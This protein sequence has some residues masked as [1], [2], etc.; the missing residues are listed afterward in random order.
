MTVPSHNH[1]HGLLSGTTVLVVMAALLAVA[2]APA[3]AASTVS[4]EAGVLLVMAAPGE[5]NQVSV[6]ERIPAP[7]QEPSEYEVRDASAGTVAGSGCAPD[8]RSP[9]YVNC[10]MAGV[11]SI[12]IRLG[13]GDD[14]AER[15]TPTGI[16]VSVYGDVGN[17]QITRATL[18]DGGEGNDHLNDGDDLRGGP[19]DDRLEGQRLLDGGDGNDVLQKTGGK[20]GGR[21]AGGSGDDSLQSDDAWADELQC[22]AGRDVIVNADDFDR[23]DGSCESGKGVKPPPK[24]VKA[25]VVVFELPKGVSRPGRDGRLAVWMRCTVPKCDVTVRIL[26][27]G[28]PGNTGE[29]YVRFRNPP[30]LR[31]V[32]G[33][34]AKLV[35]LRLNR[36]QRRGLSRSRDTYASVLALVTTRRP[37]AD[38][39]LVTDSL[40][41]TRADPCN[42]VQRRP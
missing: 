34:T 31:L 33:A 25:Q 20:A 11:Q 13:D 10:P 41:C 32:V 15:N 3:S 38:H 28:S 35:H 29:H 18:A 4:V 23:N 27:V 7:G 8:P 2:A 42:Q 24:P 39:R 9:A 30:L 40:Y 12:V 17:D 21:L 26:S 1:S 14:S 22:G 16:P 36:A 6:S 37:G 5:T 19:G